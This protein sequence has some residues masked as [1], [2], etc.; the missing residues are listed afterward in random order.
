MNFLTIKNAAEILGVT[1]MTLRNWDKSGKLKAHRHPLNNYRMYKSEDIE[2]LIESIV[3]SK[4]TAA[5]KKN[6]VKKLSVHHLE[7]Y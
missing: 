2:N 3:E 6:E 7:H 1:K 4:E 5:K